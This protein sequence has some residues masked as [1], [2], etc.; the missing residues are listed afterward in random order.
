MS[1]N[2]GM[3]VLIS[4]LCGS[5]RS[6]KALYSIVG[7]EIIKLKLEDNTLHVT[8]PDSEVV[9]YDDGQSCCEHRYMQ[10]DDDLNYFVGSIFNDLEIKDATGCDTENDSHEIQFLEIKTSKGVITFANHNEHNGYYGGFAI[11]TEK[12]GEK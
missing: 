12:L 3:G 2:L 9:I 6:I 7:K 1:T 5:E 8:T 4:R 11:V 10:T